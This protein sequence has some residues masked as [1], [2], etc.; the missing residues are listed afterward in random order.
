MKTEIYDNEG[1]VRKHCLLYDHRDFVRLPF[2]GR[3]LAVERI[4]YLLTNIYLS[5]QK[6]QQS[7]TG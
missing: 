3:V 7:F 4:I 2:G 5:W 1:S 6:Q